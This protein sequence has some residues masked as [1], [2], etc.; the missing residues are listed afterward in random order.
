MLHRRCDS[1]SGGADASACSI[2]ARYCACGRALGPQPSGIAQWRVTISI[3][4]PT[5]RPPSPTFRTLF[6]AG[7]PRTSEETCSSRY[8][9]GSRTPVRLRRRV[10]LLVPRLPSR[11]LD[12]RQPFGRV[13]CFSGCYPAL[14]RS[15]Y[16][17]RKLRASIPIR[18][19]SSDWGE[20]AWPSIVA[21]AGLC[22]LDSSGP[23]LRRRRG[24]VVTNRPS[25]HLSR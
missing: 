14:Q 6:F 5:T 20:L 10:R 25:G 19:A 8:L 9:V 11:R 17:Q 12:S 16:S 3:A 2:S 23:L 22:A 7:A 1:S 13:R 15:G 24:P 4:P 21:S 18:R